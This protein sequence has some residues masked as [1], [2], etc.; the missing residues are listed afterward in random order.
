MWL[1][2][3][4]QDSLST[5]TNRNSKHEKCHVTYQNG[6]SNSIFWFRLYLNFL[7]FSCDIGL[8]TPQFLQRNFKIAVAANHFLETQNA[9]ELGRLVFFWF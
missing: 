8:R 2:G 7:G 5:P 1:L 4:E 3:G 6:F 9:Y